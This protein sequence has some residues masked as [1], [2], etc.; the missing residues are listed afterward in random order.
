MVNAF[1]ILASRFRVLFG[2]MEAKCQINLMFEIFLNFNFSI[3]HSLIHSFYFLYFG[4]MCLMSG[5][6]M[7]SFWDF[8]HI[9]Y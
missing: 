1:R 3:T 7:F 6:V 5:S 2:T 8:L 9:S 4:V